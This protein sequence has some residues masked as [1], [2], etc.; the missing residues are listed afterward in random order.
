MKN[1]QL[2]KL[3]KFLSLENSHVQQICTKNLESIELEQE[4]NDDF[5][6]YIYGHDK[7]K[8]IFNNAIASNESIHILLTGALGTSKTL[9]LEAIN[10]N[11]AIVHLLQV[12]VQEL[13]YFIRYIQILI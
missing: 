5:F 12:I 3:A 7:L 10:E 13:E 4:E 1:L 9:F 2:S 11:V 8:L 6:K